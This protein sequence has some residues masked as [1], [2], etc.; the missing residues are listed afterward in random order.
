VYHALLVRVRHGIA[1]AKHH[2]QRASRRPLVVV[3]VGDAIEDRAQIVALHEFHR[4]VHAPVPVDSYLVDRDDAGVIEL[5]G[6]L[7]LLEEAAERLIVDGG[8]L[9]RVLVAPLSE[10]DLQGERSPRVLVEDAVDDAH[11][12][13]GDRALENVSLVD[14][15]A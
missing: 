2:V 5:A 4:E 1:D 6:D 10:H 7:R 8:R 13:F 14:G 9:T 15:P 11:P 3:R 12:A